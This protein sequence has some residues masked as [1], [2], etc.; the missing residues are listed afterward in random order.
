MSAIQK[1][2]GPGPNGESNDTTCTNWNV[3]PLGVDAKHGNGQD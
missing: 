3:D 2:E 1:I